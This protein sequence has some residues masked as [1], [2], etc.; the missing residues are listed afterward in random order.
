MKM[1]FERST[2]QQSRLGD[3]LWDVH[4]AGAKIVEFTAGR[5]F[6]EFAANEALRAA[7]GSM[8]AIMMDGLGAIRTEFPAEFA[9]MED[10]PALLGVKLDGDQ[11]VWRAAEETVPPVVAQAR[12]LLDAWHQG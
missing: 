1:G 8:L 3:L 7:V 10:A 9:R 11:K 6:E 12:E 4:A 5:G 2:E